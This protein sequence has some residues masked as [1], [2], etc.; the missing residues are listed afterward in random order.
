MSWKGNHFLWNGFKR[1]LEKIKTFLNFKEFLNW[2]CRASSVS[3]Y[4]NQMLLYT[5][6]I[7]SAV[8]A[9]YSSSLLFTFLFVP[10]PSNCGWRWRV[11]ARVLWLWDNV[12]YALLGV[13]R[14]LNAVVLWVRAELIGCVLLVSCRSNIISPVSDW[15][16]WLG[17][18]RECIPI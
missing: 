13:K 11:C 4:F 7:H 1:M 3:S 15:M 10:R 2:N 18:R 14:I 17:M 5:L 9:P 6:T 8:H 12:C 16:N